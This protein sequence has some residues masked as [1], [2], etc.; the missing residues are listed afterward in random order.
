MFCIALLPLL[1]V[2][3]LAAWL[4]FAQVGWHELAH[5][6]GYSVW[7]GR[8]NVALASGGVA[9][10]SVPFGVF[11]IPFAVPPAILVPVVCYRHWQYTRRAMNASA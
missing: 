7:I 2:L 1:A 3:T 8:G 4:A 10:G 11:A 5:V 6:R 9:L